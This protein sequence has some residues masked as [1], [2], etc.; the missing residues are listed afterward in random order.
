MLVQF[1]DDCFE[2]GLL[3]LNYLKRWAQKPGAI[4]T[5]FSIINT[6][7]SSCPVIAHVP[8]RKAAQKG[9][10]PVYRYSIWLSFIADSWWW[11]VVWVYSPSIR[12]H[13]VNSHQ[14]TIR[15]T[16]RNELCCSYTTAV[17]VL[18]F[19][20]YWQVSTNRW[21]SNPTLS[22]T[23]YEKRSDTILD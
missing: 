4:P 5:A 12:R 1:N 10:R 19:N 7:K 20:A 18:F 13:L 17:S 11:R 2:P 15:L 23:S 3:L 21:R 8:N 22:R 9:S 16:L 14:R 6:R